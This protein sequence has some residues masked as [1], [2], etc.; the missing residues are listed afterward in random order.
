MRQ[1]KIY[2]ETV[3]KRESRVTA[4]AEIVEMTNVDGNVVLPA[5]S[6]RNIPI[7]LKK[8]NGAWEKISWN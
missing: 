8:Q 1:C 3:N 6:W 2:F 7:M 5:A 4:V